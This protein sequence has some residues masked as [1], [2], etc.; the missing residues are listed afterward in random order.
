M[1][2]PQ[3]RVS[4]IRPTPAR[5]RWLPARQTVEAR[6]TATGAVVRLVPPPRPALGEH[7][8]LRSAPGAVP[9]TAQARPEYDPL[10]DRRTVAGVGSAN[11]AAFDKQA[12]AVYS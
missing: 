11:A 8:G 1:S 6:P 4:S 3:P 7:A 10:H 5:V 2:D 12:L 9:M